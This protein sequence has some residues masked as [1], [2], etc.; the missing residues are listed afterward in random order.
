MANVC[1]FD[2]AWYYRLAPYERRVTELLRNSK[3]KRARKLAKKRVSSSSFSLLFALCAL[4]WLG[5]TMADLFWFGSWALSE[6]RSG[7]SMI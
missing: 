7:R 5:I 6:E 1:A 2:L 4:A 3:D